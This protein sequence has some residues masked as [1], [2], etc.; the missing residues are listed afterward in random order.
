V[1]TAIGVHVSCD[2]CGAP[3]IAQRYPRGMTVDLAVLAPQTLDDLRGA[4]WEI[5]PGC[6]LCDRC[7][8]RVRGSEAPS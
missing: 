7:R 4:G 1:L 8:R 6:D 5:E 2:V 3:G